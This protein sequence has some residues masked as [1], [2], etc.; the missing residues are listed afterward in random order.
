[1][2]IHPT[3]VIEPGAQ[4][5]KNITIGP[6]SY[7]DHDVKIGDRC[8][9]GSHV[10]ILRYTSLGNDCR[11]HSG[12]VLGDLPQ[13]V[14]FKNEESYVKIGDNCVIREGVTIHRGTKQ[15]TLTSVGGDCLLM[16]NSHLAHNV[17]V[18]NKVII[19][20]GALLAGYV[21]VGDRA[22][23]SGNCLVH[24]FTRIGRLVMLS[25]GCAVHKDVPPFCMTRSVTLNKIMGLNNVGMQRAGLGSEERLTLKRAFKILYQSNLTTPQA[26]AQLEEEF[27]SELVLELCEF[28]KA[29]KRGI[30]TFVKKSREE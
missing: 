30:C 7:I 3:A 22:F 16:A 11:V 26:I 10:T 13:D 1:M 29:S 9:I 4:L 28:I 6:F 18:G 20:N 5:G 19:A 8:V 2:T 15:G 12:A 25:G 17:Q 27:T 14:A 23:I 21:E 24:Q